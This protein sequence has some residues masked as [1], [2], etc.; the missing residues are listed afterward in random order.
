MSYYVEYSGTARAKR[1]NNKITKKK[2]KYWNWCVTFSRNKVPESVSIVGDITHH[3]GVNWR[4]NE[5]SCSAMDHTSNDDGEIPHFK[6]YIGRDANGT[7]NLHIKLFIREASI[8]EI[9]SQH[10]QWNIQSQEFEKWWRTI[11]SNNKSKSKWRMNVIRNASW[12]F[13]Y[14]NRSSSYS[15]ALTIS[16]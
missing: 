14:V 2:K 6:Q 13:R 1:H 8:K 10:S 15:V 9:E 4:K 12:P 3:K 11:S 7:L 5:C 16:C